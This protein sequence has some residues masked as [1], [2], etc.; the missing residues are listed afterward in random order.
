MP[1]HAQGQHMTT[2]G[3]LPSLAARY[4]QAARGHSLAWAVCPRGL[5]Q[6]QGDQGI[7][8]RPRA[9]STRVVGKA[10][11]GSSREDLTAGSGERGAPS[12]VPGDVGAS[13]QVRGLCTGM[14]A[15]GGVPFSVRGLGLAQGRRT[16]INGHHVNGRSCPALAS[17]CPGSHLCT[18]PG[19]PLTWVTLLPVTTSSC[20]HLKGQQ[21]LAWGSESLP[22][23]GCEHS[24]GIR[25]PRM[26]RRRSRG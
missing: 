2:G 11:V 22:G 3:A 18:A 6:V 14:A 21:G 17:S 12:T 4:G 25:P 26:L 15:S 13:A 8:G 19:T 24:R 9:P 23:T 1:G 10:S 20:V 5:C 7:S 16:I